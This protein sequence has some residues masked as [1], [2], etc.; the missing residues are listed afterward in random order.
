MGVDCLEPA[1]APRGPKDSAQLLVP[2][3]P[4]AHEAQSAAGALRITLYVRT[5]I[6]TLPSIDTPGQCFTVTLYTCAVG[7][8]L[9]P[10]L[11][12]AGLEKSFEPKLEW[13]EAEV[14]E[15]TTQGWERVVRGDDL[16]WH[17]RARIK[18][19]EQ[20]ELQRFPFDW[21]SL[22]MTLSCIH[23]AEWP[24]QEGYISCFPSRSDGKPVQVLLQPVD[25]ATYGGSGISTS[26]T[27][28]SSSAGAGAGNSN[29]T[30]AV[31]FFRDGF[32]LRSSWDYRGYSIQHWLSHPSLSGRGKQYS[33]LQ[34]SLHFSR[35]ATYYAYNTLLPL[36]LLTSLGFCAFSLDVSASAGDRL[37]LLVTLLLTAAAYKIVVSSA[38]PLVS[39]LTR[40][41][42]YVLVAFGLL[43]L[44]TVET[45]AVS[46]VADGEL[47]RTLDWALAAGLGGAWG[48]FTLGFVA[49]AWVGG[50]DSHTGLQILEEDARSRSSRV[51]YKVM[52][53]SSA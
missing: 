12:A 23:P 10:V 22:S 17:F 48:L 19:A 51:G 11:A 2:D 20:F 21:Q 49:A 14:L 38:L 36:W 34:F 52:A 28:S 29:P 30:E 35:V 13:M 5:S 39:Y 43:V 9:R 1:A 37:S 15:V 6:F 4:S 46:T 40:L 3:T 41:D 7:R 47:R 32:L 31:L 42:W 8:G 27:G 44:L 45:A 25:A 16:E 53:W 26:G 33:N 24:N 50:R 18:F